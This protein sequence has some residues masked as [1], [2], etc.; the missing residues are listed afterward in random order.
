MRQ[1]CERG[2]Y[3]APLRRFK[4]YRIR[5]SARKRPTKYTLRVAY[6]RPLVQHPRLCVDTTPRLNY[7]SFNV[8]E[9]KNG[10]VCTGTVLKAQMKSLLCV[11]GSTC[12]A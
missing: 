6:N 9:S 5:G 11:G 12:L 2:V 10:T 1:K 7:R 3:E 8:I 4:L